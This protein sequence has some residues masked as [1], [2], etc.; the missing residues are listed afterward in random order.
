MVVV[1][2]VGSNGMLPPGA[3]IVVVPGVEVDEERTVIVQHAGSIPL[4]WTE[5]FARLDPDQPSGDVPAAMLAAL[6]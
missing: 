4:Q 3:M 2:G 6:R 5:T 1:P